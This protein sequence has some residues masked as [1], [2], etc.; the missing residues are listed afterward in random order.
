MSKYLR[1]PL[2]AGE[3]SAKLCAC[4]ASA[5]AA[6][7]GV[8]NGFCVG[9]QAETP[10]HQAKWLLCRVFFSVLQSLGPWQRQNSRGFLLA[11]PGKL[12]IR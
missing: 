11:R 4:N 8:K 9:N 5:T 7:E 3:S 6:H 10:R 12:T 2:Y 1:S